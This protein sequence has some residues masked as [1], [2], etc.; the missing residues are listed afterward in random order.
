MMK[1]R[2][3]REIKFFAERKLRMQD[4]RPLRTPKLSD[5]TLITLRLSKRIENY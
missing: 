4:Q 1:H 5:L 3:T 2:K